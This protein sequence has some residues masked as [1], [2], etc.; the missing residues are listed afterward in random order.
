LLGFFGHKAAYPIKDLEAVKPWLD[1]AQ[2]L[3]QVHP[4]A[5]AP[6]L[7][8][9]PTQGTVLEAIVAE[10]DACEDFIRQSRVLDLRTQEAKTKQEESESD[11]RERRLAAND[12]TEFG[13]GLGGD[14]NITVN[15]P[16]EPPT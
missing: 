5:P 9:V 2:I 8:T 15:K 10:C 14:I 4:K 3:G 13:A 12:L 7:V 16:A 1:F 6:Q 11:R